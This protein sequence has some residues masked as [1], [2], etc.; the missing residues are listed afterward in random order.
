NSHHLLHLVPDIMKKKAALKQLF[1]RFEAAISMFEPIR[2]CSPCFLKH[3]LPDEASTME[4]LPSF[5]VI[6]LQTS[7]YILQILIDYSPSAIYKIY[8]IYDAIHVCHE[9]YSTLS[10]EIQA[11]YIHED[12]P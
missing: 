10:K 11:L 6:A 5:S 8:N 3:L 9:E 4:R 1:Q 12:S 2:S 7:G